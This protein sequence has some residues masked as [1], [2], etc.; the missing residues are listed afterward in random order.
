MAVAT[1]YTSPLGGGEYYISSV[2]ITVT[3]DYYTSSVSVTFTGSTTIN[4]ATGYAV[5]SC[6]HVTRPYERSALDRLIWQ[7]RDARRGDTA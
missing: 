4:A 5:T 6:G 3:G 7:W 1:A 2:V